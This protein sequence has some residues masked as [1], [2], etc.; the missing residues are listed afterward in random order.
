MRSRLVS[1]YQLWPAVPK[2]HDGRSV[3]S[4]RGRRVWCEVGGQVLE[5]GG[6][7]AVRQEWSSPILED[8]MVRQGNIVPSR[9][10]KRGLDME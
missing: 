4:R 7:R 10:A 2:D 6:R 1:S 5:P 3:T 8:G 9:A